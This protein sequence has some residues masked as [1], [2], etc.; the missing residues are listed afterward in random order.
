[1]SG[2]R[3]VEKGTFNHFVG[4]LGRPGTGKSTHAVELALEIARTPAYVLAHD[5]GW[6]MPEELPNG[7]RATIFRHEDAA[8]A[9]LTMR[10]HPAGIH[11]IATT[12]AEPVIELAKE[13]AANS[14]R[15]HGGKRGIPVL[16][17]IDEVV[18]AGVCDPNRLSPSMKDL[19]AK[20]RHYNVGVIWTCQSARL[21]HNQLLTLASELRCFTLSDARDL[22]RLDEAGVDADAIARIRTLR[23]FQF[24]RLTIGEYVDEKRDEQ[25][26][27]LTEG[28]K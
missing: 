27:D 17:A 26:K 3:T 24:E 22:K 7:K 18:G 4:V 6:R 15:Q 2:P 20:R 10:K 14:L 25:E 23:K 9:L 5:N 11:A 12:D 19:I 8:S 16:V 21:V 13:I 1:M 28:P